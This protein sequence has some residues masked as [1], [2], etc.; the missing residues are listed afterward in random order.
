MQMRLVRH[1]TLVIDL[2]GHRILVDPML[3]AEGAMEPVRSAANNRRIPTMP[4]PMPV[5]EILQGVD[6]VLVTHL[7]RDHLDQAAIELLPKNLPVLCQP[8]DAEALGKLGFQTVLP[9]ADAMEHAGIEFI[10]TGGKHGT[11]L[12]GKS[13]G[14][15]S[16]FVLRSPG[17]PVL[18]IAGD[19]IWCACVREA[20][21]TLRPDVVVVNAGAAQFVT[22]SP[23]TMDGAD[24]ARV[25]ETA[26][27]AAVVAV[28][29]EAVNH[30]LL[31]RD[32]LRADL[33]GRGCADRVRIPGDGEALS[34][35][36]T[37]AR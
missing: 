16:G 8:G 31:T 25:C 20:L 33:T 30:C 29:M 26:P 4:L 32:G 6:A 10:R 18:Y 17:E 27:A 3:S 19:T 28:H 34:F 5:P 7:H 15:V 12:I 13:M 21:E 24:V 11:G 14:G 2:N 36:G 22:G 9:V 35:P 37:G 23:I 1:A